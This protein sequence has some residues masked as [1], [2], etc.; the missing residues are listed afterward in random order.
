MKERQT[1]RLDV[2][3][4]SQTW[5]DWMRRESCF[6]LVVHM[7][8]PETWSPAPDPCSPLHTH[9]HRQIPLPHSLAPES[10]RWKREGAKILKI[11][12]TYCIIFYPKHNLRHTHLGM[13]SGFCG[14]GLFC[15]RIQGNASPSQPSYT[16]K[17]NT[18]KHQINLERKQHWILNTRP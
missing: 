1:G 5:C 4:P 18:N 3:L 11:C 14:S 8:S 13:P 6:S 16:P 9:P 17:T 7:G 2:P 12:V 15:T 10:Y